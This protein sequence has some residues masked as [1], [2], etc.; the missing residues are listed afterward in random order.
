MKDGVLA[1]ERVENG[2]IELSGPA[3][4]YLSLGNEL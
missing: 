2:T 3:T 4:G 1:A